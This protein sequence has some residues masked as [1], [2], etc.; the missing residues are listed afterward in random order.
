FGPEPGN[1]W[2]VRRIADR[3]CQLWQSNASWTHVAEATGKEAPF[4]AL[5]SSKARAALHWSSSLNIELALAATVAW[6]RAF[7]DGVD[8]LEMS[9]L[10]IAE[11][12]NVHAAE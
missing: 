10:Q 5:D 8:V 4:L 12:L 6:F 7:R 2:P 11:H 3:I 1:E 9:R